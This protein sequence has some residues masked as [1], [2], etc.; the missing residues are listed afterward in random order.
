MLAA[1]TAT[2]SRLTQCR[3]MLS[4]PAL[5]PASTDDV[6]PGPVSYEAAFSKLKVR[7]CLEGLVALAIMC[8]FLLELAA[9]C[10]QAFKAQ[11]QPYFEAYKACGSCGRDGLRDAAWFNFLSYIQLYSGVKGAKDAVTPGR[12]ARHGHLG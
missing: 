2:R 3:I 1:M 5:L 6:Y 11:E 9:T 12:D 10:L 4:S 7:T 8:A